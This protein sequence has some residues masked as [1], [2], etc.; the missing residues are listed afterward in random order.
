MKKKMTVFFDDGI[1]NNLREIQA[2][3]IRNTNTT[4]S[5]SAV[6]NEILAKE[7]KEK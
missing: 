4:V 1:I 7:L 2:N 5:L 3:K 6:V